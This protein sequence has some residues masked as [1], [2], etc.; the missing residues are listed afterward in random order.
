ML[1]HTVICVIV[2][3]AYVT[4]QGHSTASLSGTRTFRSIFLLRLLFASALFFIPFLI[5]SS[6]RLMSFFSRSRFVWSAS[7]IFSISLFL[8]VNSRLIFSHVYVQC[9]VL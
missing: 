2:Y 7:D 6:L 3:K 5:F 9:A 1:P 8:F 4:G